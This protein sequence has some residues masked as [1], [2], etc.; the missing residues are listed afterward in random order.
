ME[1]SV[2]KTI[3][4]PYCDESITI[5]VDGSCAEHNYVEDCRGCCR[6]IE[7]NVSVDA[8]G[9]VAISARNENE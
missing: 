2:E 6:R 4:R 1:G 7:L 8:D 3:R 5:F 9:G